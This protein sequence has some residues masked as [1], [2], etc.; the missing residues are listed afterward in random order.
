ML[1][2]T[3]KGGPVKTVFS[4]AYSSERPFPVMNTPDSPTGDQSLLSGGAG[5][6]DVLLIEGSPEGAARF[7]DCLQESGFETTLRHERI[8]EEGL[9]A[10]GEKQPDVVVLSGGFPGSEGDSKQAE[11]VE[12]VV[13][14]APELPVVV[15]VGPEDTEVAL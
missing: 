1:E 6:L 5:P 13:G 4:K 11:A 7:E 12:A 14:T 8:L 10:L 3:F 9:E 2:G 15:L